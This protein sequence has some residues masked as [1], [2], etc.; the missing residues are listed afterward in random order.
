M[1]QQL[2]FQ[3][4]VGTEAIQSKGRADQFLIGCWNTGN[5]PVQIS[6][7]MAAL[8]HNADAPHPLFRTYSGFQGRLQC[9]TKRSTGEQ[10]L[11]L[12]LNHRWRCQQRSCCPQRQLG[13]QQKQRE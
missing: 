13:R 12:A 2:R 6:Q 9:G 10:R 5:P 3:P 11:A 7:Q 8:I 1:T 4:E